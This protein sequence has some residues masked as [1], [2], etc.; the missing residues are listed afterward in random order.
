MSFATLMVH[1]EVEPKTNARVLLAAGLAG[2]FSSTLIGISASILPS[3]PAENVYFINREIFEQEHQD[4]LVA[5]KH[6][7]ASFRSAADASGLKLEWRS[8]VDLPENYIV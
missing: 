2:R 6:T 5:L 3:Y 8:A 1:V 7:E 4:I